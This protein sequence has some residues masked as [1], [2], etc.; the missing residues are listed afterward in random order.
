MLGI[1]IKHTRRGGIHPDNL[2]STSFDYILVT[3]SKFF[4]EIKTELIQKGVPCEKIVSFNEGV[5]GEYKNSESR[6]EWV[7]KH[8]V[9]LPDGLTLLDAGAGEQ[10]YR[11]YCGHLN[12]I[13]QDFCQYKPNQDQHGLHGEKWDYSHIDIESDITCI[14]LEDNSVDVILCT[15][16]FEHLSNPVLA[17]KEFA[18]L[19][20]TSGKLILAAPFCSLTHMAPYYFQNGFSE[21]WY[22][23]HLNANGLDIIEMECN[24]NF[25]KW[26]MQELV[27]VPYMAK[28]Y[29]GMN[30]DKA[31]LKNV[32]NTIRL[33]DDLSQNDIESAEIL[34]FGHFVVAEKK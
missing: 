9:S 7:I 16:V 34:C 26:L 25:F 10:K 33:L 12:Y 20:K 21:Y 14:P 22:K 27:R 13:S 17:V 3:S 18:R 29:S 23:E 1:L 24:G 4:D 15:D 30:I 32:Y 28:L 11:K 6:E 8:L 2:A 5:F 31:R 19:L